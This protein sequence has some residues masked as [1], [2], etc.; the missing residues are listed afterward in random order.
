MA[1]NRRFRWSVAR[2]VLGSVRARTTAAAVAVVGIALIVAT[3]LLLAL[4]EGA[5]QQNVESEA[6]LRAQIVAATLEAGTAPSEL[7]IGR[8][9]DVFVQIVGPDSEV[10]ASSPNLTGD[11]PIA[12]D[13]LVG[14]RIVEGLPGDEDDAFVV[15]EERAQSSSGPLRVLV[16]HNLDS[17]TES[18][19]IARALLF[20]AIPGLLL[21]VGATTW[22]IVG[23]AL[24]PVEAIRR[25]VA[26]ISSTELHRRVLDTP[27]EDEIARLARTMN[28]M[29]HRL[30]SSQR[31]Q[32]QLVSD[33]SHELRNPI[34]AIR[35]HAEIAL[36]HPDRTTS[37]VLAEEVLKEDLRL[38]RIAED[39]LLLAQLDEGAL[40]LNARPVDLDD[41]VLEEARRLKEATELD[42]DTTGV[43]ASRV[44]GDRAQLQRV[45]RNL[46][47]NAARYA[48]TSVRLAVRANDGRV[49]LEVDDDGT[50][51]PAQSREIVF[52]RFARIDD[53]RDREHGGAG[54][55]LAIVAE[56]ALAHGGS[57]SVTD[58]PLGG[59]RFEVNLPGS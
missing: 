55:G 32:D 48:T 33:A 4:M 57:A 17:V 25:E 51:V 20:L 15:V 11:Q 9:D 49:I 8:E 34:A 13:P 7:T 2:S 35:H 3:L 42:V 56:I 37:S 19:T 27:G 5:L 47:D 30:E 46:A 18:T 10:L 22:A 41:I 40:R 45:V 38:Q 31:R 50:G 24:A 12:A 28:E 6:R 26:E 59:A 43:N 36:A 39:L 44:N 21:I 23:R 14:M 53:S 54:L 52:E 29:L 58:A 16:G 1:A